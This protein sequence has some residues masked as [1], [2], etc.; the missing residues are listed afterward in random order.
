MIPE[1]KQLHLSENWRH[2]ENIFVVKDSIFLLSCNFWRI[3]FGENTFS[4]KYPFWQMFYID[5][6]ALCSILL[7]FM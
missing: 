4:E 5:P 2:S 7:H 1:K 3:L 6:I